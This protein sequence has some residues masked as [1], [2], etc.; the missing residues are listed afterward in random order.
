[1]FFK[2][3]QKFLTSFSFFS[4]ILKTIA[5]LLCLAVGF[6]LKNISYGIVAALTIIMISPSD[7]PG[8]RKHHFLGLLTAT[9]LVVLSSVAVHMTYHYIYLLVTIISILVFFYALLSLYGNRASMVAIAGIFSISLSFAQPKEGIEILYN[10]IWQ[11]LSGLGYIILVRLFMII[12]PRQYSEQILGQTMN[13][14]ADFLKTRADFIQN[15]ENNT[16][17]QKLVTLQTQINDNFEKLRDVLLDSRSKSG[18]TN[19][20]QRQFLIFIELVN[21]FEWAVSNPVSFHNLKNL[22]K[23]EEIL[24][25][26][27]TKNLYI[28]A[29]KLQNMAL[30]ISKRKKK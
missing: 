20:L 4:G 12:K 25:K 7:I 19:Y 29:D 11:F 18:K 23:K 14:T 3:I 5:V 8:N 1:M 26:E 9:I 10:A 21:V 27:Y 24:L 15:T 13:L 6:L 16:L 22:N 17:K 30:Y 2:N 28:F